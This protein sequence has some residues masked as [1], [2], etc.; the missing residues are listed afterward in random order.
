MLDIKDDGIILEPTD[1]DFEKKAVLNPACVLVDDT[2]HLF[3]RAIAQNDISSIGYCQIKDRKVQKRSKNP[4]LAP[5]HDYESHGLEDPRITFLDG[6]YYLLY[7]AFDGTNARIAYAQSSDLVHFQKMGTI[8]PGISYE[9][10][11]EILPENKFRNRLVANHLDP[12]DELVGRSEFLWEK[13]ASLFPKKFSGK[14][15]LVHRLR[16][17]IQIAY[18]H[19]FSELTTAFWESYLKQINNF[20]ILEPKYDFENL[21]IGGGCP[22][23]MTDRGWLLIYHAV[24]INPQGKIYHAGAALLSENDPTKVIGHLNHPLFSP[25]ESWEK[26]GLVDNIVFPTGTI[27]TDN[28]LHVYYGAADR[29]IA[30]KSLD[31]NELLSELTAK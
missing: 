5:E 22:P 28:K 23:I 25:K 3:Y 12:F 26:K 18:F 15:A 30:E 9:R 2:I 13:D 20:I 16:P 19:N 17:D 4:I 6:V 21:Y 24:E 7:T 10:T 31:L 8:S 11:Q 1:E 27:I 29:C 14:F